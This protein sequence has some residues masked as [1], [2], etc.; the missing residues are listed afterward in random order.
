MDTNNS[1]LK[2]MGASLITPYWTM[3]SLTNSYVCKFQ[4][5]RE[6]PPV[7]RITLNTHLKPMASLAVLKSS[8]L[9]KITKTNSK[10]FLYN[11]SAHNKK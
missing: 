11:K 10:T 9:E 6:M 1:V 7:N 3:P 2:A 8:G 4:K 5:S